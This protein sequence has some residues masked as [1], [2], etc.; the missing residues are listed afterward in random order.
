MSRFE[1]H[2]A[3][4][5]V[6]A[7][8]RLGGLLE[9]L[10]VEGK[11]CFGQFMQNDLVIAKATKDVLNINDS[12]V[13]PLLSTTHDS[14]KNVFQ[15]LINIESELD[16][17]KLFYIDK[18]GEDVDPIQ[19]VVNIGHFVKNIDGSINNISTTC[20]KVKKELAIISANKMKGKES[21]VVAAKWITAATSIVTVV[22]IIAAVPTTGLSLLATA[23]AVGG[24]VA[25]ATSWS[26]SNKLIEHMQEQLR[27]TENQIK[28]I[29]ERWGKVV[30][31]FK[32]FKA[33]CNILPNLVKHPNSKLPEKLR[34]VSVTYSSLVF[35]L[36]CYIQRLY[37]NGWLIMSRALLLEVQERVERGKL[38]T[39]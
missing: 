9:D 35:E 22:S 15:N 18:T 24:L 34:K 14:C 8:D 38:L 19:A 37:K 3:L 29:S 26:D 1:F 39:Y 25:S 11:R 13:E 33:S 23:P 7:E 20:D 4:A 28:V 36:G 30:E 6:N 10:D 2:G 27:N 31:G 16:D 12:V 32:T 5:E 21:E 17:L